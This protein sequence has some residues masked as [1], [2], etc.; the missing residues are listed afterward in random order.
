MAINC[1][2]GYIFDMIA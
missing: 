2:L 1:E